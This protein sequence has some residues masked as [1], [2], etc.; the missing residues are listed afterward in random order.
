MTGRVKGGRGYL[1]IENRHSPVPLTFRLANGEVLVIAA[2]ETAELPTLTC[3][4]CNCTVVLHPTRARPRA[5]CRKCNA[6]CC[7]SPGCNRD[8][9]PTDLCIDLA[10]KHSRTG[11]DFLGRA[12]DGTPLFDRALAERERIF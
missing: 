9:T 11:T 10:L 4:H 8:C 3:C 2:G 7:E 12:K 1:L 6:Y 5:W